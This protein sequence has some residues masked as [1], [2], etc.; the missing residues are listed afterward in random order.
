MRG[1]SYFGR[2]EEGVREISESRQRKRKKIKIVRR[3]LRMKIWG[4]DEDD[5]IKD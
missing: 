5:R 3:L 4:A 2:V 1:P